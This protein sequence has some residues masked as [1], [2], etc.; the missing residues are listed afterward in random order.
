MSPVHDPRYSS[1]RW[2]KIAE[3]EREESARAARNEWVIPF[4]IAAVAGIVVFSIA[5]AAA[6]PE[7]PA[8]VLISRGIELVLGILGLWICATLWLG[9]VG[10]L[11]LAILRLAA[12]YFTYDAIQMIGAL[13]EIPVIPWLI[14]VVVYISML[15]WLFEIEWTDAF[16]LAIVT[17]L[18]KVLAGVALAVLLISAAG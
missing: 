4:A 9:G 5:F 15:A 14:A 2:E 10:P 1:S 13:F 3:K 6:G 7:G 18:I 12:C 11:G 17:G 16:I 8:I